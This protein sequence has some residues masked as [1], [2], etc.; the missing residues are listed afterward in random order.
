MLHTK[1]RL[2]NGGSFSLFMMKDHRIRS[3]HSSIQSNSPNAERFTYSPLVLL[4]PKG[5][6]QVLGHQLGALS[7]KRG[8]VL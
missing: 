4:N 7:G 6:R 5:I 1:V 3:F 8:S 2:G